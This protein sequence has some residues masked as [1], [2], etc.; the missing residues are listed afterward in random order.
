MVLAA[1]PTSCSA[2]MDWCEGTVLARYCH[3]LATSAAF[4]AKVAAW[5]T[6]KESRDGQPTDLSCY[7]RSTTT[8][9]KRNL[10]EVSNLF[11]RK[12]HVIAQIFRK[13]N[14]NLTIF[15]YLTEKPRMFCGPA[16]N[17]RGPVPV[18]VP[19]VENHWFYTVI[20]RVRTKIQ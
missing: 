4:T 6:V 17:L 15:S 3:W 1:C 13:N 20:N 19:P 10:T 9:H 18:C 11:N 12:P 7:E 2:L 14:M 8:E 16:K 5:P